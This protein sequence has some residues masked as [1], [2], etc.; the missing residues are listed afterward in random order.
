MSEVAP[1]GTVRVHITVRKQVART[2]V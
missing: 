2:C 1:R